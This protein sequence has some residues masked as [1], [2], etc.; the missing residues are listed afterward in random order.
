MFGLRG[1]CSGACMTLAASGVGQPRIDSSLHVILDI[2]LWTIAKTCM[3]WKCHSNGADMLINGGIYRF[4]H[5][6]LC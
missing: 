6:I 2:V 1:S 3:C 5:L 4:Y